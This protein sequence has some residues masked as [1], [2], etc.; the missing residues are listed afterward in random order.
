MNRDL[1][2]KVLGEYFSLIIIFR[3]HLFCPIINTM[4]KL[5]IKF[6]KVQAKKIIYQS[7]HMISKVKGDLNFCGNDW[8]SIFHVLKL[9]SVFD[10]TCADTHYA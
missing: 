2:L 1:Q 6:V 7:N 10:T 8:F 3:Y 9:K 5:V 4:L